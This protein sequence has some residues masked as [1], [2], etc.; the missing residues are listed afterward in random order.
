MAK[1]RKSPGS[2]HSKAQWR[3]LF[4]THKTFAHKWAHQTAGGPKVRYRRLP[5]R[6]HAVKG[7]R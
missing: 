1:P 4:A 3:F 7:R 5:A 6:V 2:M